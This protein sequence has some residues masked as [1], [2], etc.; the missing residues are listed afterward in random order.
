M[1]Y[2]YLELDDGRKIGDAHSI[3]TYLTGLFVQEIEDYGYEDTLTKDTLSAIEEVAWI[4]QFNK[5][6]II[7]INENADEYD[8]HELVNK[9]ED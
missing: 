5:N 2:H 1:N 6:A 4:M 8:V 7:S 9:K 3:L